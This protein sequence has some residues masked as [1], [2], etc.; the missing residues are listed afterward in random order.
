MRQP[1]DLVQLAYYAGKRGFDWLLDI[2]QDLNS[3]AACKI[4]V[5]EPADRLLLPEQDRVSAI[6]KRLTPFLPYYC[7]NEQSN[8]VL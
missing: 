7:Y 2:T 1:T 4:P 6:S 3:Y 5:N 8:E